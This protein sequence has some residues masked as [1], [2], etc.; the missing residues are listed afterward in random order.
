MTWEI[1]A[2]IIALVGLIISVV[3]PIAKLDASITGLKCSIDALNQNMARNEERIT[4]N[5]ATAA[6]GKQIDDHE[7]RIT[8]L[9]QKE[10]AHENG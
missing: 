2:G 6:N 7:H 1:V 8:V 3:T 9:E 4:D 10:E 5:N